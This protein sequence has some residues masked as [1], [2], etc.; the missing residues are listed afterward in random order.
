ML[1]MNWGNVFGDDLFFDDHFR[2]DLLV[3]RRLRHGRTADAQ[4]QTEN[5]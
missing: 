5:G 1:E 3:N 2:G 4:A